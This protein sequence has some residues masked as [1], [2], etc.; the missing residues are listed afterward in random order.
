[1]CKLPR[2]T[3]LQISNNNTFFYFYVR[4]L[5]CG[6]VRRYVPEFRYLTSLLLRK[7]YVCKIN[8]KIYEY[9]I[10]IFVNDIRIAINEN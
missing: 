3:H 7:N 9:Y 4:Y 2:F 10:E 5:E 1:M 8:N 6:A